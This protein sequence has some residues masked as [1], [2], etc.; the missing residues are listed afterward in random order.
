M[1]R[2]L[3]MEG[4]DLGLFLLVETLYS[5]YVRLN[6]IDNIFHKFADLCIRGQCQIC[7]LCTEGF[8]G[9]GSICFGKYGLSS[10]L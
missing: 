6:I 8:L 4:H 2:P 10:I 7:C 3:W 9:N 5:Y 1:H